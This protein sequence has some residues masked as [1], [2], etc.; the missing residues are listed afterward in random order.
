MTANKHIIAWTDDLINNLCRDH[1][2][3]IQIDITNGCC[4][5]NTIGEQS[6]CHMHARI[7][8]IATLVV[9]DLWC[10]SINTSLLY[11]AQMQRLFL[12]KGHH[13][14]LHPYRRKDWKGAVVCEL[15]K[16]TN[17]I[18]APICNDEWFALVQRCVV[19]KLMD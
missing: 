18:M 10:N 12:L 16:L 8:M 9:T 15:E 11:M 13:W 3:E 6:D 5:K 19:W 4:I 17:V 7:Y 14:N 2:S 1:L